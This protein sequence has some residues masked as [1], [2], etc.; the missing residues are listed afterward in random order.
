MKKKELKAA[1]AELRREVTYLEE[2]QRRLVRVSCYNQNQ[3]ELKIDSICKSILD[4]YSQI[5]GNTGQPIDTVDTGETSAER[6]PTGR[7]T[8]ESEE[9]EYH[10]CP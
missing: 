7:T 10:K 4:I 2:G 6:G 3:L 5:R 9:G 8:Q 1:N